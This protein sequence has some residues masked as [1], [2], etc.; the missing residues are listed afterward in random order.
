MVLCIRPTDGARLS[1][2][3][4]D[5]FCPPSTAEVLLDS[6]FT[7]CPAGHNVEAYRLYEALE[8]GSIPIVV[9]SDYY[10]KAECVDGF[11]PLIASG[12][13]FPVLDR[14]D[15]LPALLHRAKVDKE[16]VQGVQC[17]T[18]TWYQGFMANVAFKLE[19]VLLR[20]WKKRMPQAARRNGFK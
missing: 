5:T 1:Q 20:R 4:T 9:K 3:K 15:D 19:E 11:A 12:A 16:W 10:K 6:I 13:P 14:W 2:K 7:L 18:T 8:A 17:A